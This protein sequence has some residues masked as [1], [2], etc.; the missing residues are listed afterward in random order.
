MNVYTYTCSS[1]IIDISIQTP[2]EATRRLEN[3]SLEA[4]GSSILHLKMQSHQG[5]IIQCTSPCQAL[6][7]FGVNGE[8][9]VC[10]VFQLSLGAKLKQCQPQG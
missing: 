4:V 10:G 3:L 8:L 9:L 5:A 6:L 1:W 7:I 2:T